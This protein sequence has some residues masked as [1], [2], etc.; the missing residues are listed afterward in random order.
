EFNASGDDINAFLDNFM[1]AKVEDKKY[2]QYLTETTSCP[3]DCIEGIGCVEYIKGAGDECN[4]DTYEEQC[5]DK[6]NYSAALACIDGTVE[7]IYCGK[8]KT[9]LNEMDSPT[10]VTGCYDDSSI[11]EKGSA[12][13]TKCSGDSSYSATMT[14]ECKLMSDNKYHFTP[15]TDTIVS[16]SKGCNTAGTKCK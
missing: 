11:C 14:Y 4:E 6:A 9:C 16:C 8:G 15:N 5:R 13:Y 12:S 2:Y 7:A 3:Y 1:C 10:Y